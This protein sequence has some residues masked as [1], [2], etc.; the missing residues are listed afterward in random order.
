LTDFHWSLLDNF[1]WMHGYAMHFG[2]IA[3]D[4]LTFE[5]HPKPSLAWLGAVAR[6]DGFR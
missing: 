2:L 1:V 6:S 3:V 5:R 4:R